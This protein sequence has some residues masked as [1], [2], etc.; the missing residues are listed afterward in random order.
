M[1]EYINKSAAYKVRKYGNNSV[2]TIP[3]MIKEKL[4]IKEGDSL[5]FV[6]TESGSITIEKV[7]PKVDIDKAMKKNLNQYHDPINYLVDL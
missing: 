4:G 5:T 3:T 2:V 7:L 6:V 1:N